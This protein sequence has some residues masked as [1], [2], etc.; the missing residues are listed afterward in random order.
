MTT[1]TPAKTAEPAKA[2][3][4][5]ADALPGL[6]PDKLPD[7]KPAPA[8]KA[9][10]PRTTSTRTTSTRR[11]RST[12]DIRGG[13]EA[14]YGNIGLGVG[15]I[16]S[17]KIAGQ[18]MTQAQAVGATI[19]EQAGPAAEAW[20]QLA[21]ESPAVKAQ[22]EKLLTASAWSAVVGA[23]LPIAA[24]VG[25]L[26]TPAALGLG[27]GGKRRADDTETPPDPAAHPGAG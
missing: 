19:L 13:M 22:L 26:I 24:A 5:G 12:V 27:G 7:A 1:T 18:Q 25:A 14:L 17:P 11:R 20:A 6:E 9:S 2:A 3:E 16:P 8:K 4:P 10:T 15:L 21:A 23:H